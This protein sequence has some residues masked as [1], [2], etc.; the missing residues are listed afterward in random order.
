MIKGVTPKIHMLCFVL[1]NSVLLNPLCVWIL[2]R[3]RFVRATPDAWGRDSAS[4]I[5]LALSTCQAVIKYHRP[6]SCSGLYLNGYLTF[7]TLRNYCCSGEFVLKPQRSFSY[8]TPVIWNQLPVSVRHSA[9]VSSFKSSLKTFLFLKAFFF[10]P[11]DLIYNSVCVCVC[12]C[13][14][15]VCAVSYTHLTL[16][17]MAVV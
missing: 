10:S 14:C 4:C 17:T 16:P 11:I 3:V 1:I 15:C 7:L 5:H 13:V 8:Q 9:S 2:Y 12:V 6:F